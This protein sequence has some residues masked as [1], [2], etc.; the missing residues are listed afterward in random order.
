M[1]KESAQAIDSELALKVSEIF[2]ADGKEMQKYGRL[3]GRHSSEMKLEGGW[4]KWKKKKAGQW[5]KGV[6]AYEI[7]KVDI[8]GK[9]DKRFSFATNER[10]YYFEAFSAESRLKL[11]HG[12][13]LLI[14]HVQSNDNG[15]IYYYDLMK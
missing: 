13:S 15:D 4:L 10:T 7:E 11:V 9:N 14:D 1:D 6:W 8:D 12:L 3:G 2:D 5:S